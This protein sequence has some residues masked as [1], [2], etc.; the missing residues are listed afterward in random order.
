MLKG[1]KQK[2]GDKKYFKKNEN[3]NKSCILSYVCTFIKNLCLFLAKNI[4]LI[5]K[6]SHKPKFAKKPYFYKKFN[7]F[8]LIF[9]TTLIWEMWTWSR[10]FKKDIFVVVEMLIENLM[11]RGKVPLLL[12]SFH[13]GLFLERFWTSFPLIFQ[14]L[15]YIAFKIGII[16]WVFVILLFLIEF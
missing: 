5:V 2:F 10:K 14:L 7:D 4:F 8:F 6:N 13:L 16:K 15:R 1:R 3:S 11:A 9:K 12:E